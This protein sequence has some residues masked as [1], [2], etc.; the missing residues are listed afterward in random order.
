V[1]LS[2]VIATRNRSAELR[3]TVAALDE[4]DLGAHEAEIVIVDNGSAPEAAAEIS[5]LAQHA[6]L[7]AT[8]VREPT[9]GAAAARNAGLRN[10]RFEVVLFI[11]DDNP[12]AGPDVVRRHA[13][14]HESRPEDTY[15]VL[16]RVEW[17]PELDVTPLMDWLE[18]GGQFDY[19]SLRP[20]AAGPE[21]F[22]TAH[23][24]A[25]RRILSAVGGFE[26]RIP[27]LYEDADLG[28]RLF[29]RGLELD[30]HPE[31]AVHHAHTI[32]LAGWLSRQRLAGT[33]A[34]TMNTIRA[35]SP[36]LAP[37][38]SGSRWAAL[39]M[40]AGVLRLMP[41]DWAWAPRPMR[42]LAYRTAHY[43]AFAAGYREAAG[44]P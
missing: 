14:L 35:G 24:S 17:A 39:R 26:E 42:E 6:R 16:G 9:P 19:A 7:P 28:S 2:V 31:L 30:Y 3:R 44:R 29:A 40:A 10:A 33:S 11:G 21:H 4:Q 13:E 34:H 20:G 37:V 12:P 43:G 25:K 38:P 15:A 5:R 1:R 32:T 27:F 22:Y 18:H 23:V 36:P 41:T 8:V